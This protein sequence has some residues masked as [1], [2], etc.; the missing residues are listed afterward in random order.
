MDEIVITVTEFVAVFNQSMSA[1]FPQVTIQGEVSNFRISKGRWVYMDL[2]D[3]NAKISLFGSVYNLSTPLEDGMMIQIKGAPHLHPTFGFS[4]NFFSV[5]LSGKGTIKK[6]AKILEEKLK[7]EGLFDEQRKRLLPYPPQRI[8]LVT[9]GESAAYSDF[10]KVIK[11]RWKNVEII[12]VDVKV[13]GEEAA[14]QVVD[15]I[16]KLN[17]LADP[18]DVIVI[19]RGGGSSEDMQA[20]STETVTRAVAGSRIPTLVAIGHE[21]D[22]SLAEL[23]AD[24]RASTPSNAA[25]LL[26]PDTGSEISKLKDTQ[27]YLFT[28]LREKL[29]FNRGELSR[30]QKSLNTSIESLLEKRRLNLDIQSKILQANNVHHILNKGFSIVRKNNR[31]VK[32]I[33]SISKGDE[34]TI[35]MKDGSVDSVVNRVKKG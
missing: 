17:S 1:A 13:Q 33:N 34:V 7:K 32:S 15:A 30:G 25:E 6:A 8:G 27:N 23:A 31:V 2:K 12:L 3:E 20:F 10:V 22:F 29:Q 9:S 16:G 5:L 18:V 28:N 21:R 14:N 11:K 26:V 24:Q 19:T 4:V 35:N